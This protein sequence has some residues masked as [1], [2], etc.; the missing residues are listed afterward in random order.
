MH[1]CVLTNS[2]RILDM[3]LEF[4]VQSRRFIYCGFSWG[5]VRDPMHAVYISDYNDLKFMNLDKFTER[6]TASQKK[7][8]KRLTANEDTF[9]CC[10]PAGFRELEDVR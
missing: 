3:N 9:I 10:Q 8:W 6:K 7:A 1:V 5:L 4:S 2:P